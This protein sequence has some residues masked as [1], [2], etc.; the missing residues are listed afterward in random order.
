MYSTRFRTGLKGLETRIWWLMD[1]PRSIFDPFGQ[2]C[3]CNYR[4]KS[5]KSFHLFLALVSLVLTHTFLRTFD[6][7]SATLAPRE[8]SKTF[9]SKIPPAN[10]WHPNFDWVRLVTDQGR[11]PMP[12]TVWCTWKAC[13]VLERGIRII[14]TNR[15][16]PSWSTSPLFQNSEQSGWGSIMILGQNLRSDPEFM[17]D[18]SW[19]WRLD[20]FRQ[21]FEFF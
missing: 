11:R 18:P 1:W 12:P 4:R 9:K 10:D 17:I 21:C 16:P 20:L 3:F 14:P 15:L 13:S 2:V 19:W 7:R 5:I 8:A 6:D